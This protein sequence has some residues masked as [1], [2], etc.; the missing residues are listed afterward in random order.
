MIGYGS[1]FQIGDASSPPN[2]TDVAEVTNITPPSD[3]LDVVDVTHMRSPNRTRE[4]I[5]GLNDPG[6]ASITVN[7]IPGSE[8]DEA[9]QALR[10]GEV[11]PLRIIYPNDWTW[12]FDGMLTGYVPSVPVDDKMSADVDSAGA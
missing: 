6:E 8:G 3:N 11:T 9:I 7:F 10:T 2:W 1:R 12:V 4:F 5:T